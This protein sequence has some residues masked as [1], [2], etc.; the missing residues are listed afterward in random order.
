M[1]RTTEGGVLGYLAVRCALCAV[2]CALCNLQRKL[3]AP[4]FTIRVKVKGGC[5]IS[6]SIT[7]L[8]AFEPKNVQARSICFA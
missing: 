3:H 4:D 8:R 6:I 5:T 1:Q 2:R 7:K